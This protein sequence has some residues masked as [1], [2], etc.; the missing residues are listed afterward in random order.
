M[1]DEADR[2]IAAALHDHARMP[3]PVRLRGRLERRYLRGRP[4]WVVPCLSAVAGAIAGAALVMLLVR[5]AP[6]LVDPATEAVGDH[7]RVL[8]SRGL[9]VEASDMHQ[10]RPWFAGKLDF[11]PPVQFLG[12][13]E[14][15]LRGGDLAVFLGHKAAAFVYARRLH[16]I[17]L[18]VFQAPGGPV[19]ERTIQGFHVLTWA[20][21]GFGFALVSDVNFDELR[22]LYARL[23]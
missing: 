7:L 21:D 16:V 22:T 17:S 15:P 20:R 8:V 2:L 5:P 12:D 18:F 23:Q 6:A 14:F 9:G 4:P 19:S 1:T 11:V 10:V 3:A 13:D